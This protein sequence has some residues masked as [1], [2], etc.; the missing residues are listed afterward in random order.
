MALSAPQPLPEQKAFQV[1]VSAQDPQTL[2]TTWKIAPDYFLYKT[3]FQFTPAKSQILVLG[4]PI[5]PKTSKTKDYPTQGSLEVYT[6]TISIPIPILERHQSPIS[7]DIHYQG[8]SE[9]G[10]CYPPTTKTIK[11][12]MDHPPSTKKCL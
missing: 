11:I 8:C 3:H 12:N 7:V 6:G 9:Q 4:A 5:L 10:F 2:L 1:C